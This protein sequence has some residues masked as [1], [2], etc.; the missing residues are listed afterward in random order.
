MSVS[1]IEAAE[2]TLTS[3]R[4]SADGT[5]CGG[6]R[7]GQWTLCGC[8]TGP[9]RRAPDQQLVVY[10]RFFSMDEVPIPVGRK[11]QPGGIPLSSHIG[12]SLEFVGTR[13]YRPGDPVRAIHWRSFA[14]R[15]RPVVREFQ[16]EYFTRIAIVVDTFLPTRPKAAALAGFEGGISVVASIADYF[17]RSEYIVD[18]LAAGPDLY[19]VSAGRSLAYLETILD[20]LA[21][22]E[23]CHDQP[24][25]TIGPS[26]F[27]KLSATTSLVAVLL[28][29]DE[30]RLAFL[31]RVKAM[32]VAV[33]AIVVRDGETTLPWAA[34]AVELDRVEQLTTAD[35]EA[36][37]RLAQGEARLG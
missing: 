6:L 37:L 18:I 5:C 32:G 14:R 30:T 13:D 2:A 12:D 34:A 9:A 8:L 7:F 16:E 25:E 35:I 31:R 15:G 17:S 29:W 4:R 1:P 21:C 11:H 28:D 27:E 19:E 3:F 36:R 23:P 22:L 24:F 20:V 33:W 10:P 26:L